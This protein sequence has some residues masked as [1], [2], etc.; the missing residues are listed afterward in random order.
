MHIGGKVPDN[1]VANKYSD[2]GLRRR[3]VIRTEIAINKDLEP[4]FLLAVKHPAA[5][6]ALLDSLVERFPVYATI[7]NPLSVLSS[8]N[9]VALPVQ[10]GHIPAAENLDHKLKQMLL[11]SNPWNSGYRCMIT[12]CYDGTYTNEKGLF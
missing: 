12:G 9:S 3:I 10:T 6:T 2:S 11:Q 1:P 7:R 5:F 8:W 4:D